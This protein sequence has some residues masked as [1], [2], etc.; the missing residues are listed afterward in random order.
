MKVI[1]RTAVKRKKNRLS[2]KEWTAVHYKMKICHSNDPQ[3]AA[4]DMLRVIL[5]KQMQIDLFRFLFFI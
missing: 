4:E 5:K 2:G 3:A 1:L